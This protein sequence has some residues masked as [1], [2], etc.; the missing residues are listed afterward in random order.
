MANWSAL[1][2]LLF[3]AAPAFAADDAE[4]Q[5]K[6]GLTFQKESHDVGLAAEK[7]VLLDRAVA[8]FRNAVASRPDFY[9]AHVACGSTLL[10]LAQASTDSR[11]RL[12][13]VHAADEQFEAAAHCS[14]T[15]WYIY[16]A[17]A[18][19][20]IYE[21]Q[22]NVSAIADQPALLRKACDKL[23]L[24]LKLAAY[25]GD[26]V[27]LEID[28]SQSE[29]LLAERSRDPIEQRTLYQ[30]VATDLDTATRG[31]ERAGGS[32]TFCGVCRPRRGGVLRAAVLCRPVR[33][34]VRADRIFLA[35]GDRPHRSVHR[36]RAGAQYL[37]RRRAL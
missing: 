13:S 10:E 30:Q 18:T 14:N 29:Y 19:L 15:D 5:F 7:M 17:W 8:H 32:R 21:V 1:V 6:L 3:L 25:S 22:R 12:R 20:L 37:C 33:A 35:A 2:V 24:G 27:K 16:H 11:Q 28:L 4:E 23:K 36:R 34:P 31:S 26:R 9:R